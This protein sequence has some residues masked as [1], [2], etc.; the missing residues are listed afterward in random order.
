M[1]SQIAQRATSTGLLNRVTGAVGGGNGGGGG[2]G[3]T[4]WISR[5]GTALYL[6]GSPWRGA[7]INWHWAALRETNLQYPTHAQIDTV[8]DEA[9]SMNARVIRAHTLGISA[10]LSNSLVTS[11]NADGSL[12]W[13]NAAWEAIDYVIAGARQ[14]GLKLWIPFTDQFNYYHLGKQWWVQQAFIRRATSNI[15]STYTYGG[16]TENNVTS[17]DPASGTV[18]GS[19]RYKI[20]SQQ[21]YR[22][23]WIKNAWLNN[24]VVPWFNH[25][26]QYSGVANKN[27]PA[28]AFAQA[29]NELWDCGDQYAD[30]AG[31][32]GIA[33]MT[34]FSAAVKSVSP[35]ILVID[36]LGADGV[37]NDYAPGRNDPNTDMFDYHLYNN[38]AKMNAGYVAGL[39]SK[40]A[41]F[42]KVQVFGEYPYTNAGIATALSEMQTTANV[43][44]GAFWA[45]YTNDEGHS[46]GS[47]DDTVY[48]VGQNAGWKSQFSAHAGVMNNGTPPPPPP[49]PTNILRSGNVANAEAPVASYASG[50]V[51]SADPVLVIESGTGI[52]GGSALKATVS[53]AG[54]KW[55]YVN[56]L[57]AA[58]PVTPG[59]TYTASVHVQV[60]SGTL[61]TGYYGHITWFDSAGGYISGTTS[62]STTGASGSYTQVVW[63][64]VAPSGAAYAVP[65]VE[66]DGPA[67]GNAIIRLDQFGIFAGSS[68]SPWSAP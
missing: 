32:D 34:A 20:I 11:V 52:G 24:Y 42:G 31:A 51:D 67:S 15:P 25:V 48:V 59:S 60:A 22:N 58:A 56:S 3:A 1:L 4:D 33:L 5:T 38:G 49:P 53:G 17:F 43:G 37:N 13:N 30:H 35:N 12:V 62:P 68:A 8:L 65:Q 18:S 9:V 27:E 47:V 45:I 16:T 54:H 41:A 55:V 46:G 19:A 29:G 2:T 28:V 39:A 44:F 21:F 26:N 64:A 14:R 36:S 57:P 50:S 61:S 6:N 23:A 63:T 10:G 66:F 7:G 40:A